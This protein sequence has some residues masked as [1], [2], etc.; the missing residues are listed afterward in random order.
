MVYK[1]CM[2]WSVQVF[3]YLEKKLFEL[4]WSSFDLFSGVNREDRS[5]YSPSALAT[6][7][8]RGLSRSG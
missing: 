3:S 6:L 8:I 4:R 5:I 1:G 2:K 7:D